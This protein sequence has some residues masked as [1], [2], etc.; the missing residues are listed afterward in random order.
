MCKYGANID[1]RNQV[2]NTPLHVAA[3]HGMV[4]LVRNHAYMP[5]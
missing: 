4:S 2:G 1:A 5:Q 3:Q